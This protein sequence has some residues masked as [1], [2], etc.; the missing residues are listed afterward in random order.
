MVISIREKDARG[1]G[2]ESCR[3]LWVW[4]VREP[5]IWAGWMGFT[6]PQGLPF[7]FWLSHIH[8]VVNISLQTVPKC[9][10]IVVGF[11]KGDILAE[12]WGE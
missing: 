3:G 8:G 12:I 7:P 6:Q 1:K 10:R 9:L 5:L 11:D 2:D 4:V